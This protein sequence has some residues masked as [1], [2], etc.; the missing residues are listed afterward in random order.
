VWLSYCAF[1]VAFKPRKAFSRLEDG[2]LIC[3]PAALTIALA[4]AAETITA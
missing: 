1:P 2:L 3:T 4:G